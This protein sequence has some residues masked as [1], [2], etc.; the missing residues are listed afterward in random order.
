MSTLFLKT[1]AGA[2]VA[3]LASGAAFADNCSG[4][5]HSVGNMF[6]SLDIGSGVKVSA[7]SALS[8]NAF[9]D[10]EVRAGACAGY[11]LNA[12]D[13]KMRMVYACARKNKAGDVAVDEGTFEPGASRGTWKI[14]M[15]TGALAK[16][17]GDSGWWQPVVENGKVIAGIWGGTCK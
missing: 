17:L 11:M 3:L 15:A 9:K 8:S 16:M 14:T 13:G 5:Y 2:G 1:L 12:S 6:D 10:G 7:F 4:T